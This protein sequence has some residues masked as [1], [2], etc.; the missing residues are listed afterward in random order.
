MPKVS[1]ILYYLIHV[2]ELR[3]IIQWKVWHNP[4]H[5]RDESKES[6]ATKICFQYLDKTSRSFSVVIQELHPE[7]LMP[8]CL[9]YL[10][11]RG[12]D[13]VEDDTSI[14]AKTKEPVLRKFNENLEV[15]GWHFDQN[16]P[17]EKDR[18]LLVNFR[19][20]IE[21]FQKVKPAYKA[22]IKDITRKM[23]NGMADFCLNAEFNEL[24][25]NTVEDYNLYCFYVAGLVGEGLTRMFV[26]SKFGNPALLDRPHLHESMGLFLQKT[27]IIRDVREDFDDNRKFW[28]KEIWSRHVDRFEDL[29]KPENKER[30]LNCQTDM[31]LNALEHADEC[32]FYLA[33]LR[34]QSVFNFCA[35]PQSMA[36]AT[37]DLC[38]RN[39]AM[40]ERNIKISKGQ[41]CQL[42]MEST[43]NLQLVCEVFRRH[44]HSIRKKNRPQDPNFL[45]IS[46]ACGKVERFIESLF[47]SQNVEEKLAKARA[48]EARAK[49]A[50]ESADKKDTLILFGAVFSML[51]VIT[52]SMVFVAWLM[53]ARFDMA[54]EELKKSWGQISGGGI[55]RGLGQ[56]RAI[57]AT[58]TDSGHTEL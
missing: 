21:E 35:I 25:V 49:A 16:R 5:E 28:P 10:V 43:Q 31:V 22:I 30:A 32:L 34:E 8:V 47:P 23:G 15:D 9:F 27:N 55:L 29:F 37:L 53:G 38:F 6:E 24:G 42:M 45:K 11:L 19:Y 7:L 56:N 50:T 58:D 2:Q 4:V 17:E 39:Y 40:F 1:D 46:L 14:P 41:A 44:V 52:A 54:F 13:T 51:L 33:G 57:N 12:L 36:I 3:S 26:E 48:E 20:V 18:D